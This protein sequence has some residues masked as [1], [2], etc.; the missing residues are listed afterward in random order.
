V[1]PNLSGLDMQSG[2]DTR[3]VEKPD[4]LPRGK[5]GFGETREKKM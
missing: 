4:I 5:I 3:N 1:C 2:G